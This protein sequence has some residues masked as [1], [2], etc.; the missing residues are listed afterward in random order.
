ML[1][2]CRYAFFNIIKHICNSVDNRD[3]DSSIS[4]M[5]RDTEPV[6]QEGIEESQLHLCICL[7]CKVFH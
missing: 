1:N 2:T 3:T 5:G 4:K 6:K 7:Y